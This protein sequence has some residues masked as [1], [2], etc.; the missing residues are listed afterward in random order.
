[1]NITPTITPF[2]SFESQAEEA[3]QF[4]TSIVPNSRLIRTIHNPTTKAPMLV[5]FE[6]GGLYMNAL[7]TGQKWTPSNAFSLSLACDSQA[8]LDSIWNALVDGGKPLACGWLTDRYGVAWQIVPRNVNQWLNPDEPERF[9]R[10]FNAMIGMV[11][12]DIAALKSAYDGDEEK[13]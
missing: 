1:M 8:E 2:L 3:V 4:Y 7:N 6:L 5:E 11:K 10:Y 9:Q 13:H 12:L